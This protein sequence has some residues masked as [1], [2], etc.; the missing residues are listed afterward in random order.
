MDNREKKEE[1]KVSFTYPEGYIEAASW[2]TELPQFPTQ[3][4]AE[5]FIANFISTITIF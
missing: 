3:E 4:A 5:D 1:K 2:L